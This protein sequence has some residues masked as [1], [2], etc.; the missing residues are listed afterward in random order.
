M[1]CPIC[2]HK[3]VWIIKIGDNL[4]RIECGSIGCDYVDEFE[5]VE[6]VK[7]GSPVLTP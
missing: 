6:G 4:Y 7:T 1:R 5:G 3:V 2:K